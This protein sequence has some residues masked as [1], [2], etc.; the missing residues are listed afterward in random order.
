MIHIPIS[1]WGEP[2]KSSEFDKIVHFDTGEV[3]CEMS[4][5]V[6]AMVARDMRFAQRARDVLRTIPISAG[7]PKYPTMN[8]IHFVWGKTK[9]LIMDSATVGIPRNSPDGYYEKVYWDVRIS[10]GGAFVH[11]APWSVASQGEAL[12]WRFQA[13]HLTFVLLAELIPLRIHQKRYL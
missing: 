7:R 13:S 2:Y 6:A 12:A 1:R 10:Y 8:G 9:N 11:A 3:V 5:A 4:R